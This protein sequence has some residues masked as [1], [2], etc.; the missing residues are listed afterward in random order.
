[1]YTLYNT[2]I[3]YVIIDPTYKLAMIITGN[4]YIKNCNDTS[5]NLVLVPVRK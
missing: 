3:I 5:Y 2:G 4:V 1:M